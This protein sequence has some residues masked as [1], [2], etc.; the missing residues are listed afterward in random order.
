[1]NKLLS[2]LVVL[3]TASLGM[4]LSAQTNT[5]NDT[6]KVGLGTT[7][8]RSILSIGG[9]TPDEG[10]IW[11]S[12]SNIL[13]HNGSIGDAGAYGQFWK[14]NFY[15]SAVDAG[16][17]YMD[18]ADR[19]N[20]SQIAMHGGSIYFSTVEFTGEKGDAIS[21][22]VR[23]RITPSGNV[24]IGNLVPL[25][26]FQVT[27]NGASSSSWNYSD[28]QMTVGQSGK[29]YV[30]M[31][32]VDDMPAIQ[33]HGTGTG[34][35][36]LLNPVEGNVGIGTVDPNA[37]LELMGKSGA[38]L[39]ICDD[40]ERVGWGFTIQQFANLDGEIRMAGRNLSIQCGWDKV[41]SIGA[42]ELDEYGGKIVFPGGNVGIG[43]TSPENKL[44][45]AGTIRAEEIIVASDW[46][47]FVFEDGYE[48]PSLESVEQHIEKK[49]HLPGVP[50]SE[51][52]KSQGLSLGE[53]QALMMQKLEELTLYMIDLKKENQELREEL[54]D[55][56]SQ[57]GLHDQESD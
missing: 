28:I 16:Q 14:W 53:S 15:R 36:L 5:I 31:G 11:G 33:G 57:V 52:V 49:G 40:N 10:D 55:L 37:T 23:M 25:S 51:Q 56:R 9:F 19:P 26:L 48:L 24:G 41:L 46:A 54:A 3:F 29:G 20:A 2:P 32:T 34:H 27:G 35:R 4:S 47:D 1:M 18:F 21:V 12:N 7:D 50:S 6:G 13:F 45:V 17:Y 22:P 42:E 44:D 43:T 8:P 30:S 39:K 38:K